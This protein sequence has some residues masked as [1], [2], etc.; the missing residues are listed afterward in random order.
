MGRGQVGVRFKPLA[1]CRNTR[2]G[3]LPISSGGE[4]GPLLLCQQWASKDCY[5]QQVVVLARCFRAGRGQPILGRLT[6]LFQADE[7]KLLAASIATA[8]AATSG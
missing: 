4:A 6:T 1:Q 5:V 2:A 7:G 8:V 3:P